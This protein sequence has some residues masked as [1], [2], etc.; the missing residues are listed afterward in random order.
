MN[1]VGAPIQAGI[2]ILPS[3]SKILTGIR[4]ALLQY[5]TLP[6]T[7]PTSGT[8]LHECQPDRATKLGTKVL[9]KSRVDDVEF[10]EMG[11]VCMVLL[12]D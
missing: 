5:V 9:M 8:S 6:S 12:H 2:K 3:A 10:E 4:E 7:T 11:G 1:V